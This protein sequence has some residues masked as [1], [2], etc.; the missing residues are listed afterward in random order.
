[1]FE[2]CKISEPVISERMCRT[3]T[4]SIQIYSNAPVNS[5]P[6]SDISHFLLYRESAADKIWKS[7]SMYGRLDHRVFGLQSGTMYD[8]VVMAT[9]KNGE[10]QVS[11]SV[12]LRTEEAAY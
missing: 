8:F 4:H 10:C 5:Y 11:N 7:V 3:Y 9:S 6:D 12:T 2:S 1:M